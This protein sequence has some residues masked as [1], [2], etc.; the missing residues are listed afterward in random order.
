MLNQV[1]RALA[2]LIRPIA[3]SQN[4]TA[5][6][7]QSNADRDAM[8]QAYENLHQDQ[9]QKEQEHEAA[10]APVQDEKP[11]AQVIPF[12][13]KTP[14]E[15]LEARKKE[16]GTSQAWMGLVTELEGQKSALGEQ[17]SKGAGPG[18]YEKATNGTTSAARTKKGIILDKKA[19]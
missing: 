17:P 3:A 16:I 13:G 6:T 19:A 5:Q 14:E 1:T 12:A 10:S 11:T 7:A 8:G 2:A 18:A 4:R 15:V 9:K